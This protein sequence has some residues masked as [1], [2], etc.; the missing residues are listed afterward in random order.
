MEA[1]RK[2]SSLKIEHKMFLPTPK[3]NTYQ[4]KVWKSQLA[5]VLRQRLAV[6]K[7]NEGAIPCEPPVIEQVSPERPHIHMLKLMDAS[8]NSA[9]GVGQ[10]FQSIL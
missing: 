5:H 10:V 3:E 6:P 7:K 2:V 4:V 8:D 9:E 1:V